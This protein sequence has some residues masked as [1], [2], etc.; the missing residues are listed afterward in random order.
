MSTAQ[1]TVSAEDFALLERIKAERAAEAKKDEVGVQSLEVIEREDE[2]GTYDIAVKAVA[3]ANV[4]QGLRKRG[5]NWGLPYLVSDS[6]HAAINGTPYTVFLQ[7]GPSVGEKA[8]ATLEDEEERTNWS[9]RAKA[10]RKA[11][12]AA[13]PSKA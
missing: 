5:P 9:E 2:P 3:V 13:D 7:F 11:S 12:G 1:K 6:S 4:K 10:V 8:M